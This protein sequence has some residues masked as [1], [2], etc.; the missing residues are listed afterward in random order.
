MD[1]E[2]PLIINNSKDLALMIKKYQIVLIKISA[3]W[4]GPCNNKKF[5]EDYHKLKQIYSQSPSIK[6]IELDI[7]D[8][9][10][11]IEDKKYYNIDIDSVPTFLITNNGNFTKKYVGGGYLN[12]IFNYIKETLK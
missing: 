1:I 3:S 2:K 9:N 6:F 7:D 8:D 12:D 11:M 10:A 5:I 4:C